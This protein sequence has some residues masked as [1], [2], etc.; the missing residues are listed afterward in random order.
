MATT[1]DSVHE[2]DIDEDAIR[3]SNP[4]E[5]G[6]IWAEWVSRFGSKEA[7]RRWLLIFSATDA[8]VTG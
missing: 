1:T 3:S 7:S 5:L 6:R 8:P 4:A 2:S